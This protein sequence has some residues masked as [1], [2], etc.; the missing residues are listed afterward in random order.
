[1]SLIDAK[2]EESTILL[3]LKKSN[4]IG[5]I[6]KISLLIAYKL[7]TNL[8]FV[9]FVFTGVTLE[10]RWETVS[11]IDAKREVSTILLSLEKS[12]VIGKISKFH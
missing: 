11:L 3:S 9:L 2:R 7:F 5:K 10:G 4:V 6:S 8:G 1:M 12:N